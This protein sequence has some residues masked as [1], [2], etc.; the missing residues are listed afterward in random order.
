MPD[1]IVDDQPRY[2]HY[3]LHA[4]L[5][6]RTA[7]VAR[8]HVGRDKPRELRARRRGEHRGGP[9]HLPTS[10][11][12]PHMVS[13][14]ST[15]VIRAAANGSKIELLQAVVK[16]KVLQGGSK[17]RTANRRLFILLEADAAWSSAKAFEEGKPMLQRSAVPG[18]SAHADA[19]VRAGS[20]PDSVHDQASTCSV[21]GTRTG[22]RLS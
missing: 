21:P 5:Y 19:E 22:N 16:D 6:G 17:R 7:L 9:H 8:V 3:S 20:V 4:A 10:R 12:G 13:M 1:S 15:P 14:P 18:I 2:K 11:A